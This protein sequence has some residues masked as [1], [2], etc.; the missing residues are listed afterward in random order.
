MVPLPDCYVNELKRQI[1]RTKIQH[2]EDITQ[3]QESV[4]LLEALSRKDPN[5]NKEFIWQYT[6]PASKPSF[7]PLSGALRRHHIHES[8]L[9]RAIRRAAVESGIR[10][11]VSSHALRNSFAMHLLESRHDIRTVQELLGH[12]DVNTTMI[13]MHVL[14]KSGIAVKSPA[15]ML[16]I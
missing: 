2:V 1:E 6:F 14:N 12:S 5:V 8:T 16:P 7:D 10:K 11:K 4:Y 3:S 15:D 9:Q 13:Y